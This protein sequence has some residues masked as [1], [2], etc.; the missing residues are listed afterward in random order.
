ML[1]GRRDDPRQLGHQRCLALLRAAGFQRV[2]EAALHALLSSFRS[3]MRRGAD[4]AGMPR[5]ARG[6][7]RVSVATEN[8]PRRLAA[9]GSGLSKT[10]GSAS[11]DRACAGS[12]RARDNRAGR[13]CRRG[14]GS[15]RRNH[16]GLRVP[17]CERCG[18]RPGSHRT[19]NRQQ[20]QAMRE[21][22]EPKG[23]E[24]AWKVDRR[25]GDRPGGRGVLMP[26]IACRSATE[27]HPQKATTRRRSRRVAA[28]SV[29]AE[30]RSG[31]SASSAW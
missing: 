15:A 7:R 18:R 21:P 14:G 20:G 30:L 13:A 10:S 12:P 17:R 6:L 31:I 27:S 26:Q 25:R 8:Q 24:G 4:C 3:P 16:P 2:V 23:R 29:D 1:L 22:G 19:G 5:P 11:S 28:R 9:R